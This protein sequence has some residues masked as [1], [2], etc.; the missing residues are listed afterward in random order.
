MYLGVCLSCS[1]LLLPMQQYL[2]EWMHVHGM[3]ALIEHLNMQR[4]QA[5][6]AFQE[7]ID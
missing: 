5:T 1:L 7:A 4:S 6:G 2:V 3:V